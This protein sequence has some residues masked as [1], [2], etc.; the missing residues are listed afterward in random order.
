MDNVFKPIAEFK[1][2]TELFEWFD[3]TYQGNKNKGAEFT[4]AVKSG[5]IIYGTLQYAP[6]E[7]TSKES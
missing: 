4:V 6:E 1:T 7:Y 5:R 2:V 3:K